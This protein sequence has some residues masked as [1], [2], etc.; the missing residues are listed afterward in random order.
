MCKG[1]RNNRL[2]IFYNVIAGPG[3]TVGAF[4]F[5]FPVLAKRFLAL[6]Q[7]SK[8]LGN[9]LDC[10][11]WSKIVFLT[12]VLLADHHFGWIHADLAGKVNRRKGL[13]RQSRRGVAVGSWVMRKFAWI[14]G[15]LVT[16]LPKCLWA[17]QD[18]LQ[19]Y[20]L[21]RVCPRYIYRRG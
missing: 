9:C 14:L 19:R 18:S 13:F 8:G 2:E 3:F 5:G 21:S 15:P 16:H 6:A 1:S 17:A 7:I 20:P 4:L 10:L 12:S 11:I